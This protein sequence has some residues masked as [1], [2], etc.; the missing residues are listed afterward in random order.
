MDEKGEGRNIRSDDG[1]K[2]N[3]NVEENEEIGKMKGY[4]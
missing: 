4:V 1:K 2:R 3:V